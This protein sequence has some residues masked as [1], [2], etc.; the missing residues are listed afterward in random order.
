M[1]R[2]RSLFQIAVELLVV[3]QGAHRSLAGVDLGAYRIQMCSR[4]GC[5]LDGLLAAIQDA[6]HLLE[7][8]RHLERWF[9]LDDLAVPYVGLP[10]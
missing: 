1:E 4:Q 3:H 7:K 6:V 10:G 5:V 8:I 9:A 2:G